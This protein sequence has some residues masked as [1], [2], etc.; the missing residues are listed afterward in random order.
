MH[1]STGTPRAISDVPMPPSARSGPSAS[2]ARKAVASMGCS[3]PPPASQPRFAGSPVRND[4]HLV[5]EPNDGPDRRGDRAVPGLGDL[6]RL[7]AFDA[8]TAPVSWNRRWIE[9]KVQ[10]GSGSCTDVATTSRPRRSC[11]CLRRISTTSYAVHAASD[12]GSRS[13]G[14]APGPSTSPPTR[15]GSPYPVVPTNWMRSPVHTSLTSAI[16]VAS[17]TT[18]DGRSFGVAVRSHPDVVGTPGPG[19][20]TT[21]GGILGPDDAP[22]GGDGPTPGP[23]RR[24]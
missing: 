24:W 2:S 1:A 3:L 20:A 5:R 8:S 13:E 18:Y 14:F 22:W 12:N 16:Q 21:F 7:A 9:R 4:R 17:L 10:G 15:I 11:R 23:D 6:D 19:Y